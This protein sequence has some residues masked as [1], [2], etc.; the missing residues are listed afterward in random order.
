MIVQSDVHPLRSKP[1]QAIYAA[2]AFAAVLQVGPGL[3]ASARW[4]P[5]DPAEL[6][7]R[8]LRPGAE[9]PTALRTPL[10]DEATGA[11]AAAG[12]D[13]AFD[14]AALLAETSGTVAEPNEPEVVPEAGFEIRA[15][16]P[17]LVDAGLPA[18]ADHDAGELPAW[19]SDEE[20]LEIEDPQQDAP[21]FVIRS[22]DL[23]PP[24]PDVRTTPSGIP[25]LAI[26]DPQRALRRFYRALKRTADKEPRALTR[27]VHYGDSLIMGDYVTQTVRRLMQ[28]R[29]GDGGHGF[30]LAGRPWR[31]YRR[32]RLR[33]SAGG[34]WS[35][36]KITRPRA[37]DGFYGL[38]GGTFYTR[39]A[40]A[41]VRATPATPPEKPSR[42]PAELAAQLR[43]TM[44]AHYEVMYLA[45]PGGG[46]FDLQVGDR[47]I[48]VDTHAA[49]PGS[50]VA[51]LDLPEGHHAMTIRTLGG[52][53]RLFGAVV[54]R[55]GPGVVYDSL[56][57]LGA[58]ASLLRRFDRTHWHDQIRIRQPD[59][60]VLQ[61]GT[62][63]SQSRYAG[64]PRYKE[65][66][67][68]IVGHL[69]M[70]LPGVSCLLVGPMDRAEKGTDGVLRTR[71]VIPRIVQAQR[72][73]AFA[74]GCAFWDAYR[75]MGGSGSMVRWY[76]ARPQLGGGDLTHPTGR[77]AELIGAMLFASIM[78]GYEAYN[79]GR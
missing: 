57:V 68:N 24:P 41:W 52:N 60:L 34:N 47:T 48:T 66:L 30:V 15:L 29:F 46:R 50:G 3:P 54:E 43:G 16:P 59:L 63:E 31:W 40:G 22:D 28:K 38:G 21:V 39:S 20:G 73:V 35:V 56:G 42:D 51:A 27:V 14:E 7:P 64:G 9:A 79:T 49:E 12:D 67:A 8:V 32:D 76:R 58:S 13:E 55:R 69:R 17:R 72:E 37:P 4:W 71:P 70:A 26:E 65:M 2:C 10:G 19:A 45:Q 53:V 33:L 78:E 62:N 61:Y 6:L 11:V 23:P 36:Y 75:A 74:Q 18:G 77:G 44:G 25:L 1:A 5:D